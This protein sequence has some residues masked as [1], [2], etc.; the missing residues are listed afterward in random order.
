MATN[1]HNADC[2][3][4]HT[5]HPWNYDCQPNAVRKADVP[6]TTDLPETFSLDEAVVTLKW[7]GSLPG[8]SRYLQDRGFTKFR[9][10]NPSGRHHGFRWR[11]P[12]VAAP[13]STTRVDSDQWKCGGDEQIAQ[14]A[15]RLIER[16]SI[17]TAEAFY[18]LESQITTAGP[19]FCR[20]MLARLSNEGGP[21]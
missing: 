7:Q 14:A 20:D 12:V 4:F 17:A 8:L 16:N 3:R 6:S 15:L 1:V 11:H 9:W 21:F 13:P 5:T 19:R 2:P 10:S 18:W